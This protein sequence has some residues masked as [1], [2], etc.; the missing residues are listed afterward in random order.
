[1]MSERLLLG[2]KTAQ[3]VWRVVGR[4][5]SDDNPPTLTRPPLLVRLLFDR[6]EGLDLG[7]MPRRTRVIKVPESIDGPRVTQARLT[8]TDPPP[9]L[10]L[11]VSRQ[12]GR[13]FI[14]GATCHLMTGSYP[15]GSFFELEEGI[16]VTCPE[17]TFLQMARFLSEELL[18]LY[19]YEL[20]GYFAH[21][22]GEYGFCNCPALTTISRIKAYLDRLESLRASQGEGMPWGLRN[23]RAALAHVRD[24]AASPEEAVLSILITTPRRM[25][26]YGLP[27]ARMNARVRLGSEAA[28]LFDI[29]EFVCDLSWEG[30]GLVA[31][32][33]GSQHKL[34]SRRSYDLRKGNVLG[35]DGWTV[36]EVDR[37]MLERA[38][39][40]DEVAK[41]VMTG[42]GLRWRRPDARV[43]TR[44][45]RL[46]NGLLRFLDAMR[47]EADATRAA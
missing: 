41:S 12:R 30:F 32:F 29:D 42:L 38:S 37:S 18:I 44:Q 40:M 27:P 23:A 8:F 13:R 9:T 35:A 36:V 28:S 2:F 33:Q 46:R 47:R 5:L 21:G 43:A 4:R 20:C 15:A 1:M 14:A 24:G 19:G 26:G 7:S 3:R 22:M 34:R 16:M 25:G 6:G 11:C 39:L 10:D 31:E 17:L 45:A